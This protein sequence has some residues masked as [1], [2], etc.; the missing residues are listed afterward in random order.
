MPVWKS[1]CVFVPLVLVAAAPAFAEPTTYKGTLGKGEIVVELTDDPAASAGPIAG[2]YLYL[3]QG[4]D[5]PLQAKS[6][7]GSALQLSEEEA[8]KEK[9]EEGKP[10]PIGA[11]WKLT[12]S[13]DGKAIEGS[14]AGKKTLPVKLERVGSRP[15]GGDPPKTPLDLYNY[16][17]EN[18]LVEDKQITPQTSPYDYLR[19]DVAYT[20]GEK[21]GW[22]DASYHDVTDPRTKFAR[23]RIVELAGGVSADAANAVLRTR[24]WRDSI[25]AL[26]CKAMQYA[27]FQEYGPIPG[28][29]D[30]SLGGYE[31]TLAEVTALTPKLMGWTESGSVFCGGAHPEN[32]ST[33]YTMDVRTG[34]VFELADMFKDVVDGMP[35]PSLAAFV[36]EKREKPTKQDDIDFETDCGMDDLIA[37]NLAGGIKR[38]GDELKIVFSLQG[39]PHVIQA[40]NEDLLELP[41]ADAK[42]LLTTKFAALLT[43]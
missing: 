24:H 33:A 26:G 15:A 23:P 12:V 31:D 40:C 6:H 21:K 16:S 1:G 9:C 28:G 43:K 34:Q 13:A 14:W 7:Q 3:S 22:P 30:G 4:A 42:H 38:D 37:Q 2:R 19:L 20:E 17:D 41:V 32:Y 25:A 39:L 29:D 11:T 18:F 10:G 36:K 5:I 8:C 35:G 27:G